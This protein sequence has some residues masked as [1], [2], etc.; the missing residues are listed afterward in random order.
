MDAYT[1]RTIVRDLIRYW[2]SAGGRGK[3][4]GG[5]GKELVRNALWVVDHA[6]EATVV[7]VAPVFNAT[8]GNAVNECYVAG[9]QGA[10]SPLDY[11][12]Y[13]LFKAT[14]DGNHLAYIHTT[15][16]FRIHPWYGRTPSNWSYHFARALY[17]K[18]EKNIEKE[19]TSRIVDR[20]LEDA[21]GMQ[22]PDHLSETEKL[23][24]LY[25]INWFR[26]TTR[27]EEIA[28]IN[29]MY[30][31]LE[32]RGLLPTDEQEQHDKESFEC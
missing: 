23:A 29:A 25:K 7:G 1:R 16:I 20:M 9:V 3:L 22:G 14:R 17:D 15:P 27:D 10:S 6:T 12:Y 4:R 19:V 5:R 18:H 26:P 30:A 32:T 2:S 28:F 31:W 11:R 24:K 21:R 8:I 13:M